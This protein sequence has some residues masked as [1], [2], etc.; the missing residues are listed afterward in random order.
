MVAWCA[1]AGRWSPLI[2]GLGL[3]LGSAAVQLLLAMIRPGTLGFG[4]VTCTLMMGLAV[5]WFGVEA[6]LVWWLLM[7]TLGLLMLGIQQRR[8]RD[9]IP[10]APAIVLSAVIVV[11]AFTL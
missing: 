3:A 11:L 10:F 8:G 4:D 5:G 6:V 2:I 1:V 7:G 9:S